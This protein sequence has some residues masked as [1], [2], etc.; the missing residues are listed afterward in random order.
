MSTSL[1]KILQIIVLFW[2]FSAH[3][4]SAVTY[5]YVV[6][7]GAG[8]YVCHATI[9]VYINSSNPATTPEITVA[10]AYCITS[11]GATGESYDI[12]LNTNS[13]I[14]AYIES[15]GPATSRGDRGFEIGF[16]QAQQD[17]L[18]GEIPAMQ[19]RLNFYTDPQGEPL[20]ACSYRQGAVAFA[21]ADGSAIQPYTNCPVGSALIGSIGRWLIC[22]IG[23][24]N[25]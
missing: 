21:Q 3:L 6:T 2:T 25:F 5:Q 23:C 8:D 10:Q 14:T 7:Y 1:R 4:V 15:L 16:T 20:G 22:Q 24:Q 18:D 9:S 17:L 11:N 13:G 19:P 12:P